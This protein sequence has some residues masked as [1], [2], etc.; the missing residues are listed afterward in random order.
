MLSIIESAADIEE[1]ADGCRFP[2]CIHLSEPDCAV[3]A[4][5]EAGHVS[6]D[7]LES[8]HK[9]RRELEHL[10]RKA[11]P[12]SRSNVKRRWRAIQKG[13]RAARKKGWFRDRS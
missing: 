13:V 12:E 10:E 2:D 7:R 1:L 9:L 11:D 6:A 8:Y 3:K 5:V 4:A